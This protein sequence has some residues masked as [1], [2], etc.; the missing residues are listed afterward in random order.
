MMEKTVQRVQNWM[1]NSI[2]TRQPKRLSKP[3]CCDIL[4]F[5]DELH[6]FGDFYEPSE[7]SGSGASGYFDAPGNFGE[8]NESG[9]SGDPG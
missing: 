6:D 9:K 3:L 4:V 8:S 1:K 5:S 2:M 7:L